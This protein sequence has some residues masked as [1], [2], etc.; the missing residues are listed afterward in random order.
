[1][2]HCYFYLHFHMSKATEQSSNC[3][4]LVLLWRN[5]SLSLLL[6]L[7]Q[8]CNFC[9]WK[10]MRILKINYLL[11]M[12]LREFFVILNTTVGVFNGVAWKTTFYAMSR[13]LLL[14]SHSLLSKS[15]II[16]YM[17]FYYFHASREIVLTHCS[18]VIFLS[19]L[20]TSVL[21]IPLFSQILL[22]LEEYY[23]SLSF[24]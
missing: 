12:W 15:G 16:I 4:P 9:C 21:S 7:N 20:T 23:F 2:S 19:K 13:W 11:D 3:W 18:S 10:S 5:V 8:F 22:L 1:M 17:Y 24:N 6:I 14:D